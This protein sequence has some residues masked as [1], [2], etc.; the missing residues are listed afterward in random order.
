MGATLLTRLLGFR[1]SLLGY[2]PICS[3]IYDLDLHSEIKKNMA[4][5][6]HF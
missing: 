5:Q 2:W 4:C 1:V 6:I 3:C